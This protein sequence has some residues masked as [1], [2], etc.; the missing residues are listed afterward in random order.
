MRRLTLAAVFAMSSITLAAEREVGVVSHLNLTS[1][2]SPDVSTL[3]AWKQSYISEGMSDQDKSIAIFNTLTR[4]RHQANPPREFT[5]SAMAGGHV[6]DPLKSI[7][8]YGYGQCCCVSSEVVGLARYL[9]ME[10]RGRD[11][12]AHSVPE[13]HYNGGWHLFDCSVMNYH[14]KPDGQ[15]ASVDEIHEAVAGWLK[16]N[17]DY[18]GK[19]AD[20]KLRT[21]AKNG[22]WKKGPELLAKSDQFYGENGVNS[23]GWH[24]WPSTMQEYAKVMGPQEFC[25]TMGYQLNVQLRPGE[26]ITR[27]FFSRGIEYTNSMN[28]KY[29]KELLNRKVLGIQTKM[30]DAAPGRVGDGTIEWNVPLAQLKAIALSTENVEAAAA[31]KA[32]DASKPGIIVLRMPSSYVYVKAAAKLNAVIGEGGSISVS[33]SR[34]HGL[35]WTPVTKIEKSGEQAIDLTPFVKRLYD[36]QLKIELAGGGVSLEGLWTS[37]D[38]QCSQAAL[39]ALVEGENKL[40]FNAGPQEGTVTIEGTTDLDSVKKNGAPAIGDF[41][42]QLNGFKDSLAMTAGK[43]DATFDVA[44]PGDMTRLRVS[45]TWRARDVKDGL[46]L[47]ASYD[48]G[49]TFVKLPNGTLEGGVKGSSRYVISDAIPAGTRAAKVRIVGRQVNTTAIFDL[50]IDADYAEPNGGFR[51]VKMTYTWDESGTTKTHEHVAKSSSDAYS[52]T[53]GPKAVVK[54]FAME[55]AE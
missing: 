42:P 2:K 16:D 9:G 15:V 12:T 28:E 50:R 48:G 17:P 19:D 37:H 8:V 18:A 29:Y 13:I 44:T 47:Q 43:G 32:G 52:I 35:D 10:A 11:I 45:T 36:Y 49:K 46:E 25:V 6:H 41:K 22:G 7:H 21:F 26:R 3:Q 55:L 24:G 31:L 30:G 51:P 34:N 14:L 38:F 20:K 23:A 39:P 53:C 27:N 40:T 1:D 33:V 4:F 5:S 54:S